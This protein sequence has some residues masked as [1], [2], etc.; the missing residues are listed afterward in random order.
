VER[1]AGDVSLLMTAV[2]Q[3]LCG[4]QPA[5]RLR[6]ACQ[7]F[8]GVRIGRTEVLSEVGCES[9]P[10]RH[11]RRRHDPEGLLARQLSA[12]VGSRRKGRVGVSA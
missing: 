2:P 3:P 10:P 9:G 5:E 8:L 11:S 4:S 1:T 6:R 12:L 7:R